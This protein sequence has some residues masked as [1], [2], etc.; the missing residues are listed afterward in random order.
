MCVW[1]PWCAPPKIRT[2]TIE[3]GTD[4]SLVPERCALRLERRTFPGESTASVIGEIEQALQE[5]KKAPTSALPPE[6]HTTCP[7]LEQTKPRPSLSY[8]SK[9]L[10]KLQER[11]HLSLASPEKE[12]TREERRKKGRWLQVLSFLG[13][14]GFLGLPVVVIRTLSL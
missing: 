9:L 2:S 11:N 13:F 8:C 10:A 5:I 12:W 6:A 4:W 3:A 7:L 14:L 1:V